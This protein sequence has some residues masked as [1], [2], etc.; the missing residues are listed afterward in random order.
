M[1]RESV[2]KVLE[3]QFMAMEQRLAGMEKA[4]GEL[5]GLQFQVSQDSTVAL[6]TCMES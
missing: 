4:V 5:K 2:R 3:D 1:H 6:L